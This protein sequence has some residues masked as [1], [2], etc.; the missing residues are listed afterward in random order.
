VR[1][2]RA[3]MCIAAATAVMANNAVRT[4]LIHSPAG[5][6][7]LSFQLSSSSYQ[8]CHYKDP[9]CT[10]A[11][12]PAIMATLD[13]LR[14]ALVRS[15]NIKPSVTFPREPLTDEQYAAGF[16]A[17]VQGP[18]WAIYHDFI[19]PGLSYLLTP[20]HQSD[21][22]ISVL[23]IGPG[24]KSILGHLHRSLRKR[25]GKYNAFEPNVFFASKLENWLQGHEKAGTTSKAPFPCLKS[26]PVIYHT[27]FGPDRD[28]RSGADIEK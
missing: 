24:P 8:Y 21:K 15:A 14:Q 26:D 3:D 25:I 17:F 19:I 16:E 18:S 23:E 4:N 27:P 13:N 9:Q 28:P 11:S 7:A 2:G 6:V 20:R 5:R 10:R 22:L 1:Q 12:P